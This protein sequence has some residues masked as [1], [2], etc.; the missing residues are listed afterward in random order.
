VYAEFQRV[1]TLYLS[2]RG[3][4][5]FSIQQRLKASARLLLPAV[6]CIKAKPIE[7]DSTFDEEPN[8][9]TGDVED[10]DG[11]SDQASMLFTQT[12]HKLRSIAKVCCL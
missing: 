5:P 1:G 4:S 3:L 8:E 11:D 2:L 12:L 10:L 9:D 7:P 6:A